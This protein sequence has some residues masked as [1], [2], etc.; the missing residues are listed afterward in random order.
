MYVS[1][2]PKMRQTTRLGR[3]HIETALRAIQTGEYGIREKI[4]TLREADGNDKR[5]EAL[6]HDLPAFLA[7]GIFHKRAADGLQEHSGLACLD[8][9][10]LGTQEDAGA[11]RNAAAR[12]PETF[13]AFISPRAH[14]VKVIVRLEPVPEDARAHNQAYAVLQNAYDTRLQHA[15]DAGCSDVSRLCFYSYDPDIFISLQAPAFDWIPTAEEPVPAKKQAPTEPEPEP[16]EDVS[17]DTSTDENRL[18]LRDFLEN[19]GV[20]INKADRHTMPQFGHT[21]NRYRIDC[22]FNPKHKNDAFAFDS[23]DADAPWAYK[24]AHNS[25]RAYGWAEFRKVLTGTAPGKPKMSKPQASKLAPEFYNERGAFLPMVMATDLLIS[26]PGLTLPIDGEV[27]LYSDGVYR[28]DYEKRI[29]NHVLGHLGDDYQPVDG[30]KTRRVIE[31]L[32]MMPLPP[33]G[34][35]PCQHDWHI[36]VRNGIVDVRTGAITPHTPDDKWIQQLPVQFNPT[37]TCPEFDAWLHETQE[38]RM[39]D[40]QLVHEIIG[41]C[42]LQ[43]VLAPHIYI[44]YGPTHTGKLTLLDVLT[45]LFGAQHVSDVAF[46][47][48]GSKEDRFASAQLTGKLANFDRDV[49]F[50]RID[51]VGRIKKIATGELISVQNKGQ[52]R[53][54]LKPYATLVCATNQPVRSADW[55]SGWYSRLIILDFQ[56]SHLYAPKRNQVQLMTTDT[57]LSGILNHALNGVQRLL[58]TGKHTDSERVVANRARF[59]EGDNHILRWFKE[60]FTVATG[61]RILAEDVEDAF[62]TWC[63]SEKIK[64]PTRRLLRETLAQL[65]I[66]R[67]R[68]DADRSFVYH[69]IAEAVEAHE[70][71]AADAVPF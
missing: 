28:P 32:T 33:N 12:I 21:G 4:L 2:T 23:D 50:D 45:A 51:D 9:D 3:T 70:E 36:N 68:T 22:V 43:Q 35:Q 66:H 71:T 10:K 7:S 17:H 65:G 67:R 42:A 29:E 27:R 31:T 1:T 49:T 48:L 19:H 57:E 18:T 41:V 56:A 16:E 62:D 11:L 61:S 25:C 40:I 44:L 63:T 13:A 60:Q 55:T 53:F 58:E 26:T 37:A 20:R 6:K 47:E 34:E 38:G 24:C 5:Q 8:Y 64:P 46:H 15:S 39:H 59:A 54:N 30:E 69:D 14:G 52:N